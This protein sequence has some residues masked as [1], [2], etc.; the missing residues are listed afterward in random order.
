MVG[1]HEELWRKIKVFEVGDPESAFTF[2]DR[3]ARENNW[4]LEY[5]LRTFLEYKKFVFLICIADH[6]LTP[7]DEVDQ[8]WHLHLIYTE[9][10]WID[11][12]HNVLGRKIHHGPTKGG[13]DENDK[14]HNWYEETKKLYYKTF[15][16]DPP[17]DIWPSSAIRFTAVN[18]SR[19]NRNSHWII[20]KPI[21]LQK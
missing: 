14:Y 4:T 17:S 16:S 11:L 8:V 20:P 9:S 10:Y 13:Q 1:E 19:V 5:S 6:P 21:F 3:L 7:S 12:C 2:I 18:F 15:N